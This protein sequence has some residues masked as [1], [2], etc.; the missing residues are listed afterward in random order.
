MTCGECCSCKRA[1]LITDVWVKLGSGTLRLKK[2]SSWWRAR[3]EYSPQGYSQAQRQTQN[4]SCKKINIS[5]KRTSYS[6]T[7]KS[8]TSG[9]STRP[10]AVAATRFRPL[11]ESHSATKTYCE[12]TTATHPTKRGEITMQP[13]PRN[14]VWF[15]NTL[16]DDETT[17]MII[18]ITMSIRHP[19]AQFFLS[20]Q[21]MTWTLWSG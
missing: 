2:A 5:S 3:K 21:S 4:K 14:P 20:L 17:T 12:R 9:L 19:S 8:S 13:K 7:T 15:Q 11:S 16:P 6:A 18:T 1:R 10:I